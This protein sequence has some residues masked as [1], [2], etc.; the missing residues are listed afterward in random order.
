MEGRQTARFLCAS[1][2]LKDL[3]PFKQLLV[4]RVVADPEPDYR[5]IVHD[6]QGAVVIVDAG[7]PI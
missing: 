3:L 4:F 7:G 5:I 2:C 6:S 1:L